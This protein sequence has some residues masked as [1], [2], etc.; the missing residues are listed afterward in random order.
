MSTRIEKE[1]AFTAGVHFNNQYVINCYDFSL[2][3]L[4]DTESIREQNVAMERIKYF[5]YECLENSVFINQSEKKSIENY[6]NAGIKICTLPEEPYDQIVSLL[7][8]TKLN[9]ITEGRLTITDI[10]LGSKLSDGVNFCM[11]SE[12]AEQMLSDVS[13]W[14][15]EPTTSINQC[16]M[17]ADK[18]GKVVKL[19]NN[20]GEWNEIGLSW[21]EKSGQSKEIL[22]TE[23]EKSI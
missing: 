14:W 18:K 17:K 19:F 8:M 22:F 3:M 11:V 12:T 20:H 23:P 9:S 15:N 13:G 10:V 5:L 6:A 16:K 21:K 1:F 2:S 4:V 7:L